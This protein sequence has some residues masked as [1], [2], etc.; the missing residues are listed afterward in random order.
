MA[1]LPPF[2]PNRPLAGVGVLVTRPAHQADRLCALIKAAGGTAVRFPALAIVA[3]E[4][5]E[6]A[7][8]VVDRLAGF[9]LAV[10][11]SANAVQYGLALL[12]GAK[13]LPAGLSIAAIGAATAR[14]LAQ[15][16]CRV[17]LRPEGGFDSE[18]LLAAPE[19]Q[20]MA[21]RRVLIFRGQGGRELLAD[22][23]RQRGAS[24][25]YAEVY[26]R[27][28]PEA[29]ADGV[30]RRWQAG[31]IHIVTATSNDALRNL[32]DLLGEPGR[33]QLRETPL[34]V[35]STRMLKLARE[36]GIAAEVM[37]A[38]PGDDTLVQA[39]VDWR[40]RLS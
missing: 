31:D 18:A 37:V 19:L 36:L 6:A 24:V 28:R 8:A 40:H 25:E 14:A 26:R 16:G 33:S 9:D 21:G 7:R 39:I 35:V 34:V 30:L 38:A 3:P 2:D 20:D 13:G 5:P 10:F 4:D 27:A 1:A 22:A 29:S 11:I 23:L 12:G 32:Y 17:D 15:A